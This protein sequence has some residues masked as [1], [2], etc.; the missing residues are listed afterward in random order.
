M[1]PNKVHQYVYLN[2]LM[3]SIICMHFTNKKQL[4]IIH[5]V[6]NKWNYMVLHF[7]LII[8]TDGKVDVDRYVQRETGNRG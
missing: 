4:S 7:T 2:L 8:I 5:L 1:S 6:L 3:T